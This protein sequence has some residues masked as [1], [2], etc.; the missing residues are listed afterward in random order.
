MQPKIALAAGLLLTFVPVQNVHAEDRQSEPVPTHLPQPSAESLAEE[1]RSDAQNADLWRRL[2]ATEA[3]EGD[4]QAAES[5]I[6][7]AISLAPADQDIQLARANILMWRGKLAQADRQAEALRLAAPG[8][9]GFSAFEESYSQAMTEA[10]K[11]DLLSVSLSASVAPVSFSSGASETW[12]SAALGI[13]FG[14][15]A[16][17][18]FEAEA[19]AERRATSDVRIL[20]RA[21]TR[22]QSGSY[23]FEAGVTPGAT[24]RD[25]WRIGGG[26]SLELTPRLQAAFGARMARYDDGLTAAFEPG[27]SVR[28]ESR[29]LIAAKMI[30]LLD[31]DGGYRVGGAVRAD[32][33]PDDDLSLFVNIARYPDR[34]DDG[35]RQLRAVAF[36]ARL[37][38]DRHWQLRISAA[39]E[40][41]SNSYQRQS[42]NL[43]FSYRFIS[44]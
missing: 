43:S 2:A 37:N 39:D 23:Y 1:L 19:D 25:Q 28:P 32:Y 41:R 3:R 21:T 42:V 24:F 44:P 6:S 9:P 27:F 35:V 17:T 20:T 16:R 7:R 4:L 22:F 40:N 8:Y 36:G 26:A 11:F 29:I 5:A 34:E 33:D 15:P 38:L 18:V 30:N 14:N 31:A 12:E 13:A 10:K